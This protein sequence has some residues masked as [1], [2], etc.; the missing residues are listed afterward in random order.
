MVP[1]NVELPARATTGSTFAT[2]TVLNVEP[3]AIQEGSS[4]FHPSPRCP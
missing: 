3:V 1:A 4:T 2:H